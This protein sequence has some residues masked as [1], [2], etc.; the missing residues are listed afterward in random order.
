MAGRAK[1]GNVVLDAW[2]N[3]VSPVLPFDAFAATGAGTESAQAFSWERIFLANGAESSVGGFAS[4]ADATARLSELWSDLAQRSLG[5]ITALGNTAN[6][7]DPL[8][9]ALEQSF[10]V[11]GDFGGAAGDGRERQQYVDREGY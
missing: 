1:T 11:M 4:G 9:E 6:A 7:G 3:A 2:I 10:S 8:G 5:V